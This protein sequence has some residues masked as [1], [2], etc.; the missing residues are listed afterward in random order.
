[1]IY[2]LVGPMGVGKSY[3]GA[4]LADDTGCHFV[5]G[6]MYLPDN[7]VKKVTNFQNLTPEEIDSF[8]INNL[9]PEVDKIET[10]LPDILVAQALYRKRNRDM[11]KSHF[12]DRCAFIRVKASFFTTVKRLLG[13]KNGLRW[14]LYGLL[15]RP[16]FQ[17]SDYAQVIDNN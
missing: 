12:G 8:V 17:E 14:A 6:D 10:E 5:D 13:R 7:M 1:M 3:V 2:F 16:F 4:R 9:I 11:I 15:N